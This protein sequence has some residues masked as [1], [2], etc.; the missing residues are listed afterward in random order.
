MYV[1]NLRSAVFFHIPVTYT[2][3]YK[4]SI[5]SNKTFINHTTYVGTPIC[6]STRHMEKEKNK[7]WI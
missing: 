2:D 6:I 4:T 3:L 1:F 7:T 5:I